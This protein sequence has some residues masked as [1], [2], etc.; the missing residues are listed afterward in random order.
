MKAM[1]LAA[2]RGERMRPLTDCMPKPLLPVAGRPLLARLVERMV[3][4]RITD[5]VI[6]VSHLGELIESTLGD[7][8]ALGARIVYSR[9]REALEAAGGIAAALPLLGHAPFIVVNGDVYS[10]FDLSSLRRAAE[11]LSC[12][13]TLAHLVLVDN[14]PHHPAGDFF[15]DG[16]M[17]AEKGGAR[18]TFSGIGAY[19]PA[20]FRPVPQG[21]RFQLAALLRGPIAGR[22]V[23]GEHHGGMWLDVGTPERLARLESLL[24]DDARR[25]PR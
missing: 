14:P 19:H 2:G 22:R 11:L 15:L 20:L 17:L 12:T 24:A 25:E 16:S 9:E 18:L 1:I 5:I 7:G 21:A 13:G 6:N 23:S 3:R 10:D 8:T 4:C